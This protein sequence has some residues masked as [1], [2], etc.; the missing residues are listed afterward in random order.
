MG[1]KLQ[2]SYFTVLALTV[3]LIYTAD[4]LLDSFPA[5]DKSASSI[6]QFFYKYKIPV[7]LVF[8]M[9]VV[10]DYRLVMHSLEPKFIQFGIAL[11]GATAIYL[12]LN[13]YYGK[14][15][16]IFFIKEVW[17]SLIY[18]IAIWGGPIIEVGDKINIPQGFLLF[19]FGLLIFSNVLICSFFDRETDSREGLRSFA[20]DFGEGL[21]MKLSIIAAGMAIIIAFI[22]YFKFTVN[23]IPVL[24]LILIGTGYLA[25]MVWRDLFTNAERYTT[26]ANLLLLLSFLAIT[27]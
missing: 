18:S 20:L 11:G 17:I 22:A 27:W 3:W 14:G 13:R 21:T 4:H 7:F 8:L 15:P 16:R 26:L 24:V 23:G 10:F 19:S 1:V 12:L 2:G 6:H 5:G 9:G 25:I